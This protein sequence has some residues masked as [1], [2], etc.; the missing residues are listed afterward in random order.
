MIPE[1]GAHSQNDR[2][3]V[4]DRKAEF[5]FRWE[6]TYILLGILEQV[7]PTLLGSYL[8]D[9]KWQKLNF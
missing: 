3:H 5:S 9:D 7:L 6:K 4:D 1:N 2:D 8:L